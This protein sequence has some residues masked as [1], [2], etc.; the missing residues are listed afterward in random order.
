MRALLFDPNF[1]W[2]IAGSILL[3][4]TSGVIGTF[5]LLRGRSL[6]GDVLAHS[7]LPGVCIA[8][9][10]TQAKEITPLLIGAALAGFAGVKCIDAI[11]GWTRVKE[12]TALAVVLTVFFGLGIVLLTAIQHSGAGNQAGLDDFL[13]GQAAAMVGSDVAVVALVSLALTALVVLFFK[14]FKVLCFDP[15][16]AA[17]V[18]MKVRRIDSL[19]MALI[20]LAVV[21]GLQAVGVVLMAALL[22]TPAIA[23]RYWTDRLGVMTALAGLFGGLS[24]AAG[25]LLSTVAPKLPT[26]PLTVLSA[27]AL[28]LLSLAFAPRR[29]LVAKALRFFRLRRKIARENLLREVYERYE[30]ALSRPEIADDALLTRGVDL[31]HMALESGAGRRT[32]R[33]V[34]A[35]RQEGLLALSEENGHTLCTLTQRGLEKAWEVVHRHRLWEMF[36]MHEANLGADHVD[37]DADE[38]EHFLD[39]SVIEELERLLRLHNREPRLLPSVHPLRGSEG[40]GGTPAGAP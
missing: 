10:L 22:V 32:L 24:G 15:G 11:T 12:E 37:R 13:F 7:A 20:V 35:L 38:I 16:F 23:A 18:G 3:G 9:L 2:V 17:G 33:L 36:L 39:P 19:L 34:R 1:Q 29:G 30:T 4:I 26:G 8:F 6:L 27:T 28:F 21:I 14:E 31:R 25:T 5:A 40:T